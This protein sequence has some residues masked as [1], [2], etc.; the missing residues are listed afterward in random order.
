M[1]REA[2]DWLSFGWYLIREFWFPVVLIGG[3]AL[4]IVATVWGL[5]IEESRWQEFKVAHE[6]KVIGRMSGDWV[7]GTAIG[8]KGEVIVTSS[9]TPDKTGWACNDGMQYWR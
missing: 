6:C 1:L 7:T 3:T 9:R 2:G 8:S 4:L 5:I